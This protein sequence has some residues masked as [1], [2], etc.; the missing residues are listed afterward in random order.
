MVVG[1]QLKTE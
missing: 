1:C